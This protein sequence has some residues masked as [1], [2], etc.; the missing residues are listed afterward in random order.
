M[1][2]AAPIVATALTLI[3]GAVMFAA[4]GHDPMATFKAFFITP[5][6]DLNAGGLV[7]WSAPSHR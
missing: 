4:L 5:L 2:V 3:V 6:A 7:G 1:R